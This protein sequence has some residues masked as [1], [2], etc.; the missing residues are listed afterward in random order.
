MFFFQTG[1][2][3]YK[4]WQL[5]LDGSKTIVP[6]N[7]IHNGMAF[8]YFWQG[9]T[10]YHLCSPGR[11]VLL[12]IVYNRQFSIH[13]Y[14]GKCGRICKCI[15]L[16]CQYDGSIVLSRGSQCNEVCCHRQVP[17]RFKELC[18]LQSCLQ[19]S[20]VDFLLFCLVA[21]NDLVKLDYRLCPQWMFSWILI[22]KVFKFRL[23]II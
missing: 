15:C 4:P 11:T 12:V 23:Y 1:N 9:I 6:I 13:S 8:L 18:D 19:L 3:T 17:T 14:S 5:T 7:A 20:C 21:I 16:E 10:S 22:C 2:K